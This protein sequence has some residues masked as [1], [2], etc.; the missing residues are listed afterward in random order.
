MPKRSTYSTPVRRVRRRIVTPATPRMARSLAARK[1]QRLWRSKRARTRQ[2][3]SSIW[4]GTCKSVLTH[5]VIPT[6]KNNDTLWGL[7]LT[8]CQQ[9]S[10]MNQRERGIIN[11]RGFKTYM[12]IRNQNANGAMLANVAMIAPKSTDTVGGDI[13]TGTRFFRGNG[14]VRAL[15]FQGVGVWPFQRFITPINPDD[16]TII[17]H[18]RRVLA[19]ANAA[20]TSQNHGSRSSIWFLRKYTKLDRAITYLNPESNVATDGRIYLVYWFGREGASV[21][22]NTLL[23][24]AVTEKHIMYFKEPKQ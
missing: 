14:A 24:T 5:D 19:P 2:I 17:W 16:Y 8:Q 9:G 12:M 15:D 21:S 22:T 10:E 7:D 23:E 6:L 11:C 1:I 20:A 3:G 4:T 18:K 13:P